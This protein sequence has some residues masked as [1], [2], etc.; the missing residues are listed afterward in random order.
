MDL[1]KEIS[2][3]DPNLL[4]TAV[5][6]VF[7]RLGRGGDGGVGD[8]ADMMRRYPSLAV[9][10]NA[11]CSALV[12]KVDV[13]D[14]IQ[15]LNIKRGAMLVVGVLVEYAELERLNDQFQDAVD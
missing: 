10:P 1:S 6:S 9:L 11:I 15:S 12:R 5:S 3:L 14:N 2:S 4:S 8:M 13:E 7:G